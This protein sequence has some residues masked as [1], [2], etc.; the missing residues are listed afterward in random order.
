MGKVCSAV[1]GR[2]EVEAP[3]AKVCS[4]F[5]G[6]DECDLTILTPRALRRVPRTL[7][8]TIIGASGLR[9]LDLQDERILCECEVPAQNG[10]EPQ[11]LTTKPVW[12]KLSCLWNETF[13]LRW[14]A[15][16]D[17]VSFKILLEGLN[18]DGILGM[19]VLVK[20]CFMPHGFTGDL[21]VDGCENCSLSVKID[22]KW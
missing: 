15:N 2:Q 8:I 7:Q 9:D 16:A 22:L 6:R 17:R 13:E 20:P 10:K 4:K 21:A 11:T 12:G 18:D 1:S 5:T 14:P 19:A 3:V